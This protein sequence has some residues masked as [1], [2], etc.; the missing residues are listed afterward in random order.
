MAAQVG[1]NDVEVIAQTERNPVPVAAVIAAAV[2]EH[3]ERATRIPP[4]DVMKL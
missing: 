2:Y 4:I 1:R 3:E